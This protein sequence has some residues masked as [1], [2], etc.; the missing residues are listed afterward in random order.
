MAAD[1]E[2]QIWGEA[3]G[4]FRGGMWQYSQ[5]LFDCRRYADRFALQTQKSDMPP[6]HLRK[7]VKDIGDVSQK[8]FSADK[9]AYLGSLKYMVSTH[10]PPLSFPVHSC[11]KMEFIQPECLVMKSLY[12]FVLL[13]G[14]TYER[15]IYRRKTDSLF[16]V[17]AP[18]RS[19][20][21][22]KHAHAMGGHSRSASALP[23]QRL[24]HP[25]QRNTPSH[26]PSLRSTV[27]DHVDHHATRE[28]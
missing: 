3:E 18:C 21:T 25:R 2:E 5:I 13:A 20:I 8:K 11:M 23:C 6:E 10:Y 19:Q 27:G 24:P 26:S 7:I 14:V 16:F 28:G 15:R 12:F 1:T 4:R 17:V 22:R 9:R